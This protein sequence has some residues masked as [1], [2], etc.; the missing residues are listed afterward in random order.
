M[1]PR[2]PDN[3]FYLSHHEESTD[4][5]VSLNDQMRK[6]SIST[7]TT[8]SSTVTSESSFKKSVT[9][10]F[11]QVREYNRVVGDHPDVRIGPPI[12]LG[13]EYNIQLDQSVDDYEASRPDRRKR[14]LRLSSISRKNL[15]INVFGFTEHDIAV[16]E[17]EASKAHKQR[18][19]SNS[20]SK[21]S[22]KVEGAVQSAGRRLRKSFSRGLKGLTGASS[23]VTPTMGSLY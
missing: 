22:R 3:D 10:S 5:L 12:S 8:A 2:E 18:E 16:A 13:W 9:F 19:Q 17:K 14:Y 6:D 20:Q 15:L 1:S 21:A 11:V 23:L 7:S 4:S